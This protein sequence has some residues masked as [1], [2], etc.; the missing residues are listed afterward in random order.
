MVPEYGKIDHRFSGYMHRAS[1][2]RET[3]AVSIHAFAVRSSLK[4]LISGDTF[5]MCD[6]IRKR[7]FSVIVD[8]RIIFR[9]R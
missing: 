5:S 7:G 1:M 9:I 6:K 3:E 2:A 8:P 4:D